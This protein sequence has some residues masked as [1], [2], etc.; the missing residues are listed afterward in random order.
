MNQT[1]T[2]ESFTKK[3]QQ[4]RDRRETDK[5]HEGEKRNE[6][7]VYQISHKNPFIKQGEESKKEARRSE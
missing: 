5:R 7:G 2:R 1:N 3:R 6:V 4:I